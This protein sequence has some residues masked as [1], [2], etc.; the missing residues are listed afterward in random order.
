MN[1]FEFSVFLILT[2]LVSL[3]IFLDQFCIVIW[4]PFRNYIIKNKCCNSCR[5][6]SWGYT[7]IFLN[8][9]LIKSFWTYTI[10]IASLVVFLQWEFAHWKHPERFYEISNTNLMCKNCKKARGRCLKEN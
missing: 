2:L 5:I 10:A 3:A 6:F 4:C 9:F 1:Y 7:M 8:F